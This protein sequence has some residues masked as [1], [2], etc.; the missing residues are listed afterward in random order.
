MPVIAPVA[1]GPAGQA[2]NINADTAAGALAGALRAE[3]FV[4]VSDVPGVLDAEGSLLPLLNREEIRHLRQS[5]VISGGM[6]PKVEACLQALDAGCGRALILDG[7][8]PASLGR[9]L[10]QGAPLGTLVL[11]KGPQ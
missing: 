5:G 6:I 7:R 2:L 8:A 3:T 11:D 1:A 9:F 4:L 10:L